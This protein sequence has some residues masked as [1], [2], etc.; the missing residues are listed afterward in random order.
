MLKKKDFLYNVK[1]A[2]VQLHVK[3][4]F[5]KNLKKKMNI[6]FKTSCFYIFLCKFHS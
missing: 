2:D 6:F 1:F 5:K 3:E 4:G